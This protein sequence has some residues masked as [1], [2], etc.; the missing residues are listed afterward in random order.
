M[1][2]RHRPP[3]KVESTPKDSPIYCPRGPP[4]SIR[5][6]HALRIPYP[7]A[8]L[9]SGPVKKSL[10]DFGNHPVYSLCQPIHWRFTRQ[11]CDC[12]RSSSANQVFVKIPIQPGALPIFFQIGVNLAVS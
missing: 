3:P 2:L 10:A 4:D 7:L 5:P 9:L 8:S 1:C 11:I 6:E 12:K